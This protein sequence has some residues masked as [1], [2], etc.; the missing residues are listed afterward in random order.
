MFDHKFI[1]LLLAAL[2]DGYAIYA[3]DISLGASDALKGAGIDLSK[4]HVRPKQVRQTE[5]TSLS[6]NIRDIHC[7]RVACCGGTHLLILS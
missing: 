3:R 5:R 6:G 1:V 4:P 7:E 2:V